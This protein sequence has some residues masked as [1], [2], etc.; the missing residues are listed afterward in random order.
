M[1]ASSGER[2]GSP[3]QPGSSDPSQPQIW[4]GWNLELASTSDGWPRVAG[5]SPAGAVLIDA[6][7]P[8]QVS[9][10]ELVGA[11]IQ[12]TADHPSGAVMRIR[13]SLDESWDVRITAS[14]PVGAATSSHP[15]E[16]PAPRWRF[17]PDSPV[18]V[19][20]AGA[21]GLILTDRDRRTGSDG[22]ILWRQ[23]CGDCRLDG[24]A[25]R[26]L[27]LSL[28]LHPGE[29]VTSMWRGAVVHSV[30]QAAAMLP[31]W[32]PDE[33][34]VDPR[35]DQEIWLDTPDAGLLF[36]GEPTDQQL[37]AA[38]DEPVLH[39]VQVRQARGTTRLMV[40][41]APMARDHAWGRAE[42]ILAG[43][44][45]RRLSGAQAWILLQGTP[46]GGA[47]VDQ[48]AGL[49]AESLENLLAR[50]GA[51]FFTVV[52]AI[53][54]AGQLADADIWDSAVRALGEL[55]PQTSG[56]LI[57]HALARSRAGLHDW[58]VPDPGAL[59]D[60][61]DPLVRA[62]RAILLG[63]ASG[64]P[65]D[66]SAGP[67]TDAQ[68]ALWWLG[69]A[70]PSPGLRCLVDGDGPVPPLRSAWAVALTSLWPSWWPVVTGW[71]ADVTRLR[72][73]ATRRLLLD[74]ELGDEELALLLW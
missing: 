51:D 8:W 13:Q 2:P 43:A 56:T 63:P 73:R 20:A 39:E 38:V 18:Q 37:F 27:G 34:L 6:P 17:A 25:V 10:A 14:L 1:N 72:Q 9:Q 54:L 21:D 33:L 68:A 49:V 32:L 3:A 41:W 42:Q 44:D 40:G 65:E 45:P 48:V 58:Q 55:S 47:R 62:E 67:D 74:P 66:P 19:W 57:A 69:S 15:V 12:V 24:H 53:A 64:P 60:T 31:C 29:T 16:V 35:I 50:P 36:D 28:K 5:D 11:E 30:A 71:G 22:R 46:V 23:I 4:N 26:P 61:S 70:L 59:V 52:S 7:S